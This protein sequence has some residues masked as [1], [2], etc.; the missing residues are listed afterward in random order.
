M[1]AEGKTHFVKFRRKPK[2]GL[3]SIGATKSAK[4]MPDNAGVT[5]DV[6]VTLGADFIK[7]AASRFYDREP[8]ARLLT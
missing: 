4:P 6:G 3:Q 1:D 7:V 8:N 5:H 2:L